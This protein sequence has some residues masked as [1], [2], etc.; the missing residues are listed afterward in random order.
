MQQVAPI[1]ASNLPEEVPFQLVGTQRLRCYELTP[2]LTAYVIEFSNTQPYV[3]TGVVEDRFEV[4]VLLS[5]E[6]EYRSGARGAIK[7][8]PG[9]VFSVN[10]GEVHDDSRVKVESGSDGVLVGFRIADPSMFGW[11]A[12]PR[13]SALV[14]DAPELVAVATALYEAERA[15]RL[16]P[17]TEASRAVTQFVHSECHI[18]PPDRLERAR[19]LIESQ[20]Q[21]ALYVAHLAEVAGMQ[22]E[23]FSRAFR[24][25]YGITPIDYRLR[26]RLRVG[27]ERLLA[28]PDTT[29]TSVALNSGFESTRFFRMALRSRGHFSPLETRAIYAEVQGLMP[30]RSEGAPLMPSF[31]RASL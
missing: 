19:L 26:V 14:H 1:S 21:A 28:C 7:L 31:S 11:L 24:R 2:G 25:R 29:V 15:R 10:P 6:A 17:C 16:L 3:R 9:D 8:R 13:A 18:E 27:Q 12:L 22:P 20:Y 23:T 4:A 30:R 5:G